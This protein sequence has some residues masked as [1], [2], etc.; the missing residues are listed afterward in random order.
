MVNPAALVLVGIVTGI[1][2]AVTFATFDYVEK[3]TSNGR[4]AMKTEEERKS[5]LERKPDKGTS[6]LKIRGTAEAEGVENILPMPPESGPPLP[7]AF[8]LKWPWKK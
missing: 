2:G 3:V 5:L 4:L 1:G 7:R 6:P 8:G